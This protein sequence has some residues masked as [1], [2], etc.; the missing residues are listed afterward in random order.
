[1]DGLQTALLF[2]NRWQRDR[3]VHWLVCFNLLVR[4]E[5]SLHLISVHIG[6]L[7]DHILRKVFG[8]FLLLLLPVSLIQAIIAPQYLPVSFRLLLE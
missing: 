8:H 7:V 6:Q 3:G 2:L 5:L 1:M 4:Q